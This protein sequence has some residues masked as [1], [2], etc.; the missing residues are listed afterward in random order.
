MPMTVALS[1]FILFIFGSK[2]LMRILLIGGGGREHAMAWRMSQSP[3]CEALFIA[4]GNAGTALCGENVDLDVL[5]FDKVAG[6]VTT[7]K[8]DMVV[9]GPEEPLVRGMGDYFAATPGLQNIMFVGPPSAGAMLEGSKAFA[10]AF[11]ERHNIPTAAYRSFTEDHLG[12]GLEYIRKIMPPYVLKADGLAAGKGVVISNS[13]EEAERTLTE[14]LQ[15]KLFGEASKKVVVEEFLDGREMSVFVITDGKNYKML[16]SAKDYKR[17]GEHDTGANTGGMGTVSPVPF[18]DDTLMGRV[19]EH[20]IKP[21]ING[22]QEEGIPYCGFIFFGLMIVNG[23]PYVI[24]YNV[25]LGDP[26]AE[27]ILPRIQSDFLELLHYCSTGRLKSFKVETLPQT[28]L[29]LMLC[30]GG[31]PGAYEKGLEIIGLEKE[32]GQKLFY[33]GVKEQNGKYL[34]AGGRVIAITVLASGIEEARTM[35]YD[36]ASKIDFKGMYYRRDIGK[37]LLK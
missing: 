31:Y 16:P 23:N 19:E 34:T 9:V 18:A 3:L 14:M 10:K 6:F 28:A 1:W 5:D 21:T 20:I 2:L 7:N 15:G 11:M 37:D 17:V 35:A 25:R 12:E 13:S 4:P 24:E 30:S 8:L 29:T 27:A 36:T 22:L 32:S 26:E 33:A